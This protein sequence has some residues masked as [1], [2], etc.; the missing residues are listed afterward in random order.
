MSALK[1]KKKKK[2][3]ADD[4]DAKLAEVG[5]E[6]GAEPTEGAK[7]E[8]GEQEGD[9][10]EGTGIWAH[11]NTDRITYPLLLKRFFIQ[12]HDRHPDLSGAGSKSTKIPPPQC[13]REGNKKTIFA[14][15]PDIAK[16]LKRNADHII[17]FLF[18]ELGTYGSV[19][20]SG[21]LVIK[22]RFSS[23]Q[24]EN[25]LRRYIQEYVSCKTCRSLN[26]ELAKGE[27]RLWYITCQS[28]GSRRTVPAINRG[29]SALVGKRKRMQA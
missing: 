17:Q 21:R 14:N 3:K 25:I 7:A 28:C 10:M 6:P 24:I 23:K 27:N 5:G 9:M 15:L 1:K 19:D 4:F 8:E 2:P 16:R 20:A 22:G 13:L 12:L 26:T 29:F 11:D 18:A